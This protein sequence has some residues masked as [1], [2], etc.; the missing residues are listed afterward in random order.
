MYEYLMISKKI[1]DKHNKYE[2]QYKPCS[3]YW[4]LG[5]ENEFYLQFQN[6]LVDK[7]KFLN[8]HKRERY[9][10]DY[11]Q[12]YRRVILDK[13]KL[14]G[15]LP[16]LMNSHSFTKTDQFNNPQTLYNSENSP[17]PA[18][19]GKTL[20]EVIKE[21]SPYFQEAFNTH[22]TFDGD[23]FEIIT[24][25]F[26]NVKLEDTIR[27]LKYNKNLFIE[28]IQNTFQKLNIFPELNPPQ[29]MTKNHPFSIM[30]TNIDNIAMFNN[31]TIHFNITLPTFLDE[32]AKIR[33]WDKFLYDHKNYIKVIQYMEPLFLAVYGEPDPLSEYD[34]SYSQ[35]SQRCAVSRYIGIG[36][37]DTDLMEKGKRL[38]DDLT[39]FKVASKPYGWYRRYYENCSY[40]KLDK[41]GYD[42]NFNKHFNHGIEV[43][44]FEHMNDENKIKEALQILIYLGDFSLEN[45]VLGNPIK[46]SEWNDLV[47]DCMTNGKNTKVRTNIYNNLFKTKFISENITDLY[48]EI[49]SHLKKNYEK[50][51]FSQLCRKEEKD[52]ILIEII[53]VKDEIDQKISQFKE[54]YEKANIQSIEIKNQI[55][56]ARKI[57]ADPSSIISNTIRNMLI[58]KIQDVDPQYLQALLN[59]N[60]DPKLIVNHAKKC[61]SIL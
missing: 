55:D 20:W 53:E 10:V 12:N 18:F 40:A 57:L 29:I 11:F 59:P 47:L 28:Q 52:E 32:N 25:N 36:T 39:H 6:V 17:N 4:G 8:N 50:G 24:T 27:E 2:S 14:P 48:F 42:I 30:L 9:S 7:N 3:L 5:I 26:Y 33:Y 61:C 54:L 44:F 22:F 43:R 21:H 56:I 38:T 41:I 46:L 19:T 45:V 13:I 37:F 31:G 34:K 16:L 15:S 23:S 35:C 49:C 58:T 51:K 1:P 60:S